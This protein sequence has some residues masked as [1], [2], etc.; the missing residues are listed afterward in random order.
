MI[1]SQTYHKMMEQGK[2]ADSLPGRED[3]YIIGDGVVKN[4]DGSYSPNTT[5]VDVATYYGEY[6]RRANVEAN[7]FKAS[8]IKLRD[9]SFT[10]D[11]P[12]K[13]LNKTG[14]EAL[15][16]TAYGRDLFIISDFPMYDPE[17]AALNGNTYVPGVEMGQMPSTATYGLSLKASL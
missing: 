14:L 15:S 9:V 17:T 2:L 13:I 1:Y 4:A 10:F 12:K 11:F 8:Y 6:N 7:S 5:K 16:L 3:G